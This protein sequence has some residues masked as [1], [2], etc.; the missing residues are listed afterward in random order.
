[1][2][3]GRAFFISAASR[4]EM[5]IG[6]ESLNSM[7]LIR[8]MPTAPGAKAPWV[9]VRVRVRGRVRVLLAPAQQHDHEGC[10]HGAYRVR[11]SNGKRRP[12]RGACPRHPL[13]LVA[14]A[15]VAAADTAADTVAAA[16]AASAASAALARSTASACRHA[17]ARLVSLAPSGAT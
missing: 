1:M 10:A 7:P 6:F 17:L 15:T 12:G 2:L 4:S 14:S 3:R 8:E 16:A 5:R 9:R 13:L 11:V